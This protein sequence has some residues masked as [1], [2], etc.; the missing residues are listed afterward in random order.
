VDRQRSQVRYYSFAGD[1]GGW[2]TSKDHRVN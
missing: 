1:D 2:T